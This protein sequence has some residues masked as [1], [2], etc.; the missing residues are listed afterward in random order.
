MGGKRRGV[1]MGRDMYCAVLSVFMC[2]CV[3]TGVHFLFLESRI[4]ISDFETL[5]LVM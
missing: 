4:V 1:E 2:Y 5:K 3:G